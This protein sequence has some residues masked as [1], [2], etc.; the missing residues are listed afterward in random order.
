MRLGKPQIRLILLALVA[1]FA[2]LP[3]LNM[4]QNDLIYDDR[5]YIANDESIFEPFNMG[6]M[7]FEKIVPWNPHAVY[8]PVLKWWL[9]IDYSLGQWIG[10]QPENPF[11]FRLSNLLLHVGSSVVVVLLVRA[12]NVRFLVAVAAGALFAVHPIHTD[13]VNSFINR[14]ELIGGFFGLLFILLHRKRVGLGWCATAL[15]MALGGKETAVG[16]LGVAMVTD[17]VFPAQ[18]QSESAAK[19]LRIRWLVYVLTVAVWL[20][21]RDRTVGHLESHPIFV[22]NPLSNA[23]TWQRILT[24]L[25]TQLHYLFLQVVPYNLS[26]DYSFD[27]IPVI[28]SLLDWQVLTFLLIF[29]GAGLFA[30]RLRKDHPWLL[31]LYLAYGASFAVASNV[32]LPVA[33]MFAERYA[34]V[35]SVFICLLMAG[36]LWALRRVS[37]VAAGGAFVA[38]I[39]VYGFLTW[40]QNRVWHDE[41]SFYGHAAE[42]KPRNCKAHYDL[43]VVLQRMGRHKEAIAAFARAL[44][45]YPAYLDAHRRIVDSFNV[46]GDSERVLHHLELVVKLDSS[47]LSAKMQLAQ[48]LRGTKPQQAAD[49]A[50]DVA[51]LDPGSEIPY[52]LLL[53]L[54]QAQGDIAEAQRLVEIFAQATPGDLRFLLLWN[55]VERG[56]PYAFSSSQ[57]AAIYFLSLDKAYAE[58]AARAQVQIPTAAPLIGR[59]LANALLAWNQKGSL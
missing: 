17:W 37:S 45:I 28:S 57:Y 34:Y 42:V 13:A 10:L 15:F 3:Y 33:V 35:P 21:L 22:M 1:L 4:F 12:M 44:H 18:E 24:A 23:D 30:I 26:Y 8:R 47:D 27:Q 59:N 51:F 41:L 56:D 6:R 20:W 52:V 32:L 48:H 50:L 9:A 19:N 49:L 36:G 31:W 58:A 2:C 25:T 53:Q 46:V 38:I 54:A 40:K 29:F 7:L 16:F 55:Q 5:A 43:A 11:F 39:L 14:S